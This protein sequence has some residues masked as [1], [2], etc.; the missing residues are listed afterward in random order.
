MGGMKSF[1]YCESDK[2]KKSFEKLGIEPLK[3]GMIMGVTGALLLKNPKLVSSIFVESHVSIG[4][5]KAAAKVIELL[6]GYLGLKVDFKPLLKSAQD[7]E[8][9]LKGI[10]KKGQQVQSAKVGKHDLDYM[11]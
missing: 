8:K 6:D 7:F 3:E 2:G 1:Y 5:S 9:V 4:D 11:G 10:V